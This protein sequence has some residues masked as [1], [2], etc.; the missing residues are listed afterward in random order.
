MTDPIRARLDELAAADPDSV[1]AQGFG[2]TLRSVLDLLDGCD[3]TKTAMVMISGV[4]RVIAEHLG[5]TD[6]G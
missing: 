1:V 2:E 6:G 3:E 4:R 5:V